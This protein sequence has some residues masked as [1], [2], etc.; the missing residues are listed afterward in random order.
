MKYLHY[1]RTESAYNQ[2]RENNYVEP[3]VSYTEGKGLDYNKAGGGQSEVYSQIPFTIEALESG[4]ISWNLEALT[5]EYSK[6]NG[7]WT[8]MDSE[9]S[10]SVVQGDEVAFIGENNM[11]AYFNEDEE[12]VPL[13]IISTARFNAKGNIMSLTEGD[14][15]E[16]ASSVDDYAFFMLFSD[17][18]GGESAPIVSAEHLILPSTS[19][20]ISCYQ[21]MFLGCEYLVY[22]PSTLP[23]TELMASCYISMFQDCTSLI[24]APELPATTLVDYCYNNMFSGC[25]SLTTAPE[26]PAT[27]LAQYCCCR[28]FYGCT[29]L[30]TAPELPATTLTKSC[31]DSMFRGCTSLEEAPVLP[32]TTLVN[33]CYSNMFRSCSSLRQIKAMFT[34]TPGTGYTSGWVTDVSSTGT[35]IKNSSAQWSVS[36]NNGIPSGWTVQTASA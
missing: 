26:L 14:N 29:S 34:T 16:Q 9:T 20:S 24:T 21:A 2:A 31:Y 36:G 11:Y 15:F 12:Y 7:P 6:N 35:F 32:A 10:I 5:V 8:T 22:P 17:Y 13:N 19:L 1:F 30:T 4:T 18:Y 27:T 33:Q 25:T 3:W 28:M 23:A